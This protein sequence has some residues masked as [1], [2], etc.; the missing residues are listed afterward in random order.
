MP[1]FR[2]KKSDSL[3]QNDDGKV[4]AVF[5]KAAMDRFD[6]SL[7]GL[8]NINQP[9]K[10]IDSIAAVFD[11]EGF[12]NFCKQI[13]PHLSVPLFLSH[14]LKW[15]MDEIKSEMVNKSYPKG[16]S[17]WSPLPYFVKF[18]GDGLLVLWESTEMSDIQ[19]RNVIVACKNI[20]EKYSAEFAPSISNK[21]V[22]IP[23]RLRCGLA[24]GTVY[25]VGNGNDFVGSCI[26]MAARLQ[27]MPGLSFA[28]NRRGIDL[29]TSSSF[30]KNDVLIKRIE[31]RGI[32]EN[33]LVG[34][35]KAEFSKLDEADKEFYRNA[36]GK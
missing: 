25:S 24:R 36:N 6:E 28:F 12:T 13:E 29:E 2:I 33:E 34:V 17:L 14:F 16:S 21:V 31:I 18:M 35:L 30:F 23:Q 8:G 20:R 27:K 26:N 9:S 1:T 10:A 7:L 11:L 22:D 19:R 15:L 32:G 5:S 4:V 3:T